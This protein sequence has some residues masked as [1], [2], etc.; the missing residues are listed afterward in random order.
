MAVG[1]TYDE[2]GATLSGLHPPGFHALLVR[3]RVGSGSAHFRL[4]AEAV[5]TWRMHQAVGVRIDAEDERAAAGSRV[6]VSLG[7]VR[8]PCRVVWTVDSDRSA[9][10]AYGTLPGHPE[11]GEEA[12]VVEREAD[13]TVWLTVTAFS[14]PAVWWA[15]A[16]GPITRSLQ[17]AYA[18][19]CGLVLRQ[20]CHRSD[21]R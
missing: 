11:C 5:L 10:F 12:F 20:A 2:V 3:T 15:R 8:A 21:Q 1:Y 7:P 6:L 16:G 18:R 4:T 19:R 14:R 13:D 9:G 17:R